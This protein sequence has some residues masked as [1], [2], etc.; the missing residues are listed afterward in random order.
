M[1]KQ[2]QIWA[3]KPCRSSALRFNL[4]WKTDPAEKEKTYKKENSRLLFNGVFS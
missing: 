1:E 2:L 4:I 3:I